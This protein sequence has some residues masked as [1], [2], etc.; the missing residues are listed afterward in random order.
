MMRLLGPGI[1]IFIFIFIFINRRTINTA[2]PIATNSH[3]NERGEKSP[4][5][6][7]G[8]VLFCHP[9]D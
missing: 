7:N 6:V 2:T 4:R 8:P 9:A 3:P 5:E 1:F